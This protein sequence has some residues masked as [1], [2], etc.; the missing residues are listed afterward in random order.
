MAVHY[1]NVDRFSLRFINVKSSVCTRMFD[2]T[3]SF[4][5]LFSWEKGKSDFVALDFRM[6]ARWAMSKAII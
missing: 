1:N 5:S 6:D 2:T 4:G 3:D